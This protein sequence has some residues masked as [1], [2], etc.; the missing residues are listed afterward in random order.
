MKKIQTSP[1]VTF[2]AFGESINSLI[3]SFLIY[4]S[5][6]FLRVLMGFNKENNINCLTQLPFNY[7]IP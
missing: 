6:S 1:P 2:V 7:L 4:M 5:I 3:L